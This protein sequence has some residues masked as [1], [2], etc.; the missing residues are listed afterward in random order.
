[1]EYVNGTTVKTLRK[2]RGPLP[3]AEAIAYVH[4]ILAAFAY[5]HAAGMVYCDMKPDNFMLEGTPPDVKLIDMGGVRRLDDPGGDIYG[6]R[7]YSAGGGRGADRGLGLVHA[8]PHAGRA[9][10]GIPLPERLRVRSAAARPSR[11]CSPATSRSTGSCSRPRSAIRTCAFNRPTKWPINSPACCREVVAGHGP[12]ASRPKAR[13]STATP[14]RC[15]RSSTAPARSCLPDLKVRADDPGAAY[16]L[17]IAGV[18][19]LAAAGRR[20]CRKAMRQTPDSRELRLRL[21]RTL[22]DLE[23]YGRGRR[24]AGRGGKGRSLRLARGLV[25]RLFGAGPRRGRGGL[26]GVRPG[27][28]RAARRAGGEIG[29]GHGG[30][31][32]RATTARPAGLY[33]LVST[34]DPSFRHGHLRPGP[35]PGPRR[36]AG[37]SGGRLSARAGQLQ[38]PPAGANRPGRAC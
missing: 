25:S 7:G 22:I 1:M 30:R 15:T 11:R 23:S 12:A 16:L 37:R 19:D 27:L 9:A 2:E 38:P 14:W 32:R 35:L 21:A 26:H 34:T 3:P 24:D 29:R 10:D 33:D 8:R 4:R 20:C 18:P 17:S 5:L 36:Q 28:Q 6:T 13:S 31:S